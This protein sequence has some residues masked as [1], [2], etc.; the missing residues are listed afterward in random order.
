MKLAI[1]I[2][3]PALRKVEALAKRLNMS[4]SAVFAKAFQAYAP[5]IASDTLRDTANRFADEMTTKILEEQHLWLQSGA[6]T[7]LNQTKW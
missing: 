3:G 6:R 2:P 5:D 4:C 7:V 1:S